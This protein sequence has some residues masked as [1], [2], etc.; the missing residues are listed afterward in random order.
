MFDALMQVVDVAE[1]EYSPIGVD[2]FSHRVC[3]LFD[4]GVKTFLVLSPLNDHRLVNFSLLLEETQAF[5]LAELFL[6]RLSET[7]WSE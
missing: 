1:A 3:L 7:R 6:S 4:R 5:L 2:G